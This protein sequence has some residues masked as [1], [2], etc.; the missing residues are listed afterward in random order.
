MAT[1][2]LTAVVAPVKIGRLEVEGLLVESKEFAIAV[3]QIA[4]LFPYFQDSQN[5]A[6]Q[7]LKR[8]MGKDFKTHKVKT[9]FNRNVTLSILLLDLERVIRKLDKAGD[10]VAEQMVDDL[11]GLSLHQLWADAFNI[12]FE[13][14]DRQLWLEQRQDHRKQFHPRLTSWLKQDANGDCSS[15]Q[16]GSMINQFKSAANLPIKPVDEYSSTD[17]QALNVA[18]IEYNAMRKIGLSHQEAITTLS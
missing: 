5:Q 17:L 11:I 7:K 12:Q 18:E 1:N 6:S 10:R 2:I 4:S 8:L 14:Q 15:V 16:W 3:P 13:K 9:E